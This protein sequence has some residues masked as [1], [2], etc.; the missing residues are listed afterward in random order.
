MAK[1][2]RKTQKIFALNPVK[3]NSEFGAIQDGGINPSQDLD[4]LQQNDAWEDGWAS[5][6]A[7]PPFDIPPLNDFQTLDYVETSQIAYILQEG[8]PEYD[9]GTNY[10]EKSIVK[11]IG[12]YDLYGS[13][14]NDNKGNALPSA[15]A[16]DDNWEFLNNMKNPVGEFIDRQLF[17][18]SGSWTVPSEMTE[19]GYIEVTVAG[20][21]SGAIKGTS[22]SLLDGGDSSFGIELSATGG[23]SVVIQSNFIRSANRRAGEGINGDI[24]ING[25][26]SHIAGNLQHN[27]SDSM[28]ISGESGGSF[29]SNS[30]QLGTLFGNSSSSISNTNGYP[31]SYG[32]G[33]LV[34]SFD[35]TNPLASGGNGGGTAKKRISKSRFNNMVVSGSVGTSLNQSQYLGES[36]TF[37]YSETEQH[38]ISMDLTSNISLG[39]IFLVSDGSMIFSGN[40]GAL[41]SFF[42]ANFTVVSADISG[43]VSAIQAVI[44][45]DIS[46]SN[47]GNRITFKRTVDLTS[48]DVTVGIGG[49][50]SG[51]DVTDGS[52]G[53]VIV[54]SYR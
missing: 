38:I 21:G 23:V 29:F 30:I 7:S 42:N 14:I 37:T 12:T 9:T 44:L 18:S 5:A 17:E 41:A 8:I 3:P 19:K 26:T 46:V 28:R 33:G 4:V 24:N 52:D 50:P 20:A 31:K 16:S 40:D 43:I 47:I 15:G 32:L 35:E 25:G 11:Q 39:D 49:L 53:V 34:T 6:T 1:I 48:Y 45:G 36:S 22:S 27:A 2:P 13:V 54:K 10:A 51:S